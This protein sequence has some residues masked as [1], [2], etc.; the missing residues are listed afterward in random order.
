M[1]KPS[2]DKTLELPASKPMLL[3]DT[4]RFKPSEFKTLDIPEFTGDV[5]IVCK[6][7]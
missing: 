2:P 4:V 5:N 7:E 1:G 6:R 3:L